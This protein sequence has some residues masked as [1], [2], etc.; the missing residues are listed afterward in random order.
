MTHTNKREQ[1]TQQRWIQQVAGN[2]R[3]EIFP[4][5]TPQERESR[6]QI[7]REQQHSE[8][9]HCQLETE[10]I[11][12]PRICKEAVTKYYNYTAKWGNTDYRRFSKM[13]SI[14]FATKPKRDKF[15]FK[16]IFF[17]ATIGS[18]NYTICK[19]NMRSIFPT[20]MRTADQPFHRF[21]ISFIFTMNSLEHRLC[22]T[23]GEALHL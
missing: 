3:W 13:R 4:N 12:R 23:C 1:Q 14:E 10:A 2:P 19:I 6:L 16:I 15:T 20:D 21:T 18:K 8:G 5:K 7:Q 9:K 22:V 17:V 11:Q